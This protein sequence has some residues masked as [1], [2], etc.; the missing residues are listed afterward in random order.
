MLHGTCPPSSSSV[1]SP[2]AASRHIPAPSSPLPAQSQ[3]GPSL[4]FLLTRRV[5]ISLPSPACLDPLQ[6]PVSLAAPW[7]W[8]VALLWG[9]T[10]PGAAGLQLVPGKLGNSTEPGTATIPRAPGSPRARRDVPHLAPTPRMPGCEATQLLCTSSC[11]LTCS[12]R[13]LDGFA[14]RSLCTR[15][16]SGWV[17]GCSRPT[18]GAALLKTTAHQS[19]AAATACVPPACIHLRF[20]LS[21]PKQR[22]SP[23]P[24][25]RSRPLLCCMQQRCYKSLC[26]RCGDFAAPPRAS[27]LIPVPSSAGSSWP[28][29]G[30]A[31]GDVPMPSS[32]R[33]IAVQGGQACTAHG[34]S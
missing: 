22:C 3:H 11:V 15:D 21:L 19:A 1:L 33:S 34:A 27:A 23:I 20:G 5:P 25:S 7:G 8:A 31:L 12:E 24:A 16:G 28:G 2:P 26:L 32:P 10:A 9:R 14:G 30:E 18:P 29:L 4:P 6:S 17:R 13:W